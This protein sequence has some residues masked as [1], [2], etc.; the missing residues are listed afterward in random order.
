MENPVPFSTQVSFNKMVAAHGGGQVI[1]VTE[2][3]TRNK[4]QL[5]FTVAEI[6]YLP[7]LLKIC[8]GL[9]SAEMLA[10]PLAGS[11]KFQATALIA[12]SDFNRKPVPFARHES[13]KR[14]VATQGMLQGTITLV[15]VFEKVPQLEV[16]VALTV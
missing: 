2:S 7:G 15:K 3:E 12:K 16:M 13:V 9:V 10:L 14:I 8:L 1:I 6:L 11:P 4:P 5:A